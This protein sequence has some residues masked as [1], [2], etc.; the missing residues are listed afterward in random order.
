MSEKTGGTR[1]RLV[2]RIFRTL[3]G[4]QTHHYRGCVDCDTHGGYVTLGGGAEG[5]DHTEHVGH[6][7]CARVVQENQETRGEFV[8]ENVVNFSVVID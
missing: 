5:R 1:R 8:V 7:T 6:E 4:R 2:A 3:E